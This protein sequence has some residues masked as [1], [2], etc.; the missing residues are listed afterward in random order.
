MGYKCCLNCG[1]CI[2]IIHSY[3]NIIKMKRILLLLTIF[4]TTFASAQ[5]FDNLDDVLKS[6]TEDAQLLATAYIAPLGQSLTYSLNGGWASSAKTHKKFGFDLTF[7]ALS[8]SVSDRAKSFKIADLGLSEQLTSSSTTA[9]T[10]LGTDDSTEFTFTS[11][12][13]TKTNVTLPGGI[14]DDLFLNSLPTPYFQV[15]LG[16]FFD[17]HE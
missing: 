8:P 5:L 17:R 15:G 10:I 3:P 6:S 2:K 7:G 14:E 1:N 4:T 11:S 12:D 9:S 13:G 16:L